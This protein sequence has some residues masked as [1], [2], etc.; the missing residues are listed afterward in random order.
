[1]AEFMQEVMVIAFCGFVTV[2]CVVIALWMV[3]EFI[4]YI[5]D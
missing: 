2:A 3:G 1:M 4:K 5:K